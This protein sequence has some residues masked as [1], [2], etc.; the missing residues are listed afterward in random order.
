MQDATRLM[1]NLISWRDFDRN[2]L[3]HADNAP[4]AAVP[5]HRHDFWEIFLIQSGTGTH[6]LNGQNYALEAG[7]LWLIRPNDIHALTPQPRLRFINIAF[8]AASFAAWCQLA[9]LAL[10]LQDWRDDSAPKCAQ[11]PELE[12]L[13]ETLR[14]QFNAPGA[15]RALELCALWNETALRLLPAPSLLPDGAPFWMESALRA[16]QSE[17]ALCAGFAQLQ[18]GARVSPSHLAREWKRVWGV[19]PTQWI[20][21]RRLERAVT[22]LLTTELPIGEIGARCGFESSPY[23]TRRFREKF[24]QS[25]RAFRDARRR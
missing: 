9:G 17:A 4:D 21:A 25:P 5:L 3:F 11:A 15:A 12:P 13:F 8:P 18:R 22:L 10:A 19:S 2:G 20:N 16:M 14:A 1:S 23:F 6:T 24:G 7:Q